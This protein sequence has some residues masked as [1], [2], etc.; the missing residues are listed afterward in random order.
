MTDLQNLINGV[1][2]DSVGGEMSD[3]HQSC[4]GKVIA[5]VPLSTAEDVEL[6]C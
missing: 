6:L 3:V 4:N 2:V 1:W 5:R